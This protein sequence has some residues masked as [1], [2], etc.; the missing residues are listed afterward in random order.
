MRGTVD[1][2]RPTM[3]NADAHYGW[4]PVPVQNAEGTMACFMLP[5]PWSM[6]WHHMS[7]AVEA[8][9]TLNIINVPMNP[10]QMYVHTRSR[11]Q[12]HVSRST[13]FLI[14]PTC[15]RV[16]RFHPSSFRSIEGWMGNRAICVESKWTRPIIIL[17]HGPGV[18][19]YAS[20]S[21]RMICSSPVYESEFFFSLYVSLATIVLRELTDNLVDAWH[22]R[23]HGEFSNGARELEITKGHVPDTN[24]APTLFNW[25]GLRLWFS[26]SSHC[27]KREP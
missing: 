4:L 7:L 20:L 23:Y 18:Y 15:A 1:L 9:S 21:K 2:G 16:S 26:K 24:V 11:Y 13:F 27:Y 17:Y 8:R 14:L 12:L 22:G 3:G 6:A 5:R 25:P 19:G 10:T